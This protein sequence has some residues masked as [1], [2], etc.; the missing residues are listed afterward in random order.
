MIGAD[1]F[2]SVRSEIVGSYWRD[3]EGHE[4]RFVPAFFCNDILRLWRTFCVTY[5]ART[6]EETESKKIKRRKKNYKLRHARIMT[7]Y[8]ALAMLVHNEASGK[9]NSP[10]CAVDICNL[11]PIERFEYLQSK[12]TDGAEDVL[13]LYN[14]FLELSAET[15]FGENFSKETYNNERR[16]ESRRFSE[17]VYKTLCNSGKET[18]LLKRL[19]V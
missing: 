2:H 16:K 18:T 12:S 10:Q 3:Y 14:N 1:F 7:C 6:S 4:D 17:A 9:P 11:T 15:D 8:S 13:N 19:L 5:E